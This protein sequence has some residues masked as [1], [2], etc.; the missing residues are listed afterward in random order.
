MLVPN[1][2]GRQIDLSASGSGDWYV[3]WSLTVANDPGGAIGVSPASSG[4]LTAADTTATLTITA[5]QY[6]PCGSSSSPTIT[7]NPGGAVF[8]VCTSLP[9]H[10]GGPGGGG[11]G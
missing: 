7:V 2:T 11:T 8:S 9:K 4:T 6:I 1:G 5:D 10:Y 3:N